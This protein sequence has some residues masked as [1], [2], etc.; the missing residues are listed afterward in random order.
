MKNS[1]KSFLRWLHRKTLKLN[2]LLDRQRNDQH[3]AEVCR[4]GA[5]IATQAGE[6]ALRLGWPEIHAISVDLDIG[7]VM[8]FLAE[9]IRA[10]QQ[11]CPKV[12]VRRDCA[13]RPTIYRMCKYETLPQGRVRIRP[14]DLAAF[15]L[16]SPGTPAGRITL[17]QLREI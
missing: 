3:A 4:A 13:I 14:D 16:K 6:V 8:T 12:K 5:E 15:E 7:D 2:E 1:P 11:A 10:C 9:C 17:A